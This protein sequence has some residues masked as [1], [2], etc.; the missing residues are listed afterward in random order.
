MP[1]AAAGDVATGALSSFGEYGLAGLV[2]LA[3]FALVYK[4]GM[5]WFDASIK[6]EEHDREARK[7]MYEAINKHT[8]ALERNTV[9][10]ERHISA[11][12]QLTISVGKLPCTYR[13]PSL[14]TRMAD[15]RLDA[16]EELDDGN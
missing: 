7:N 13:D 6:R 1:E 3:L 10:T 4:F 15:K 8:V 11:I 14:K 5:K 2:I 16:R 12:G 9:A